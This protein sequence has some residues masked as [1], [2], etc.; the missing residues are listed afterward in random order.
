MDFFHTRIDDK[1]IYLFSIS[2]FDGKL[3]DIEAAFKD[4]LNT[5]VPFL[6]SPSK[7]QVKKISGNEVKC[8]ELV[9]FFKAY[10]DIFKVCILCMQSFFF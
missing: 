4:H 8:K 1:I 2:R 5:F 7:I 9:G 3:K 6:L 10:I